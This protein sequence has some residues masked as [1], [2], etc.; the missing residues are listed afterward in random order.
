MVFILYSL[1]VNVKMN[2][3]FSTVKM[4][5]IDRNFIIKLYSNE[6]V[7]ENRAKLYE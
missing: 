4:N 7:W 6:Y 3:E 5:R 1:K 2:N